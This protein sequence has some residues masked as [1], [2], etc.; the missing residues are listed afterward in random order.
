MAEE[1]IKT[2]EPVQPNT[3]QNEPTGASENLE[4]Q[5]QRL[6]V[7]Q[8]KMKKALD[9]ASSEAADYKKKY[10]A[11]LSEKEQERIEKAEKEAS[12]EEQFQKLLRENEIHKL[13]KNYLALGY[14]EELANK[15]AE[16]HYDHDSE[17]LFKIQG[18]VTKQLIKARES[19]WMKNRPPVYAGGE[20][21]PVDPFVEGFKSVR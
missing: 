8:A 15:A 4:E 7:E 3:E 5:I 21:D 10:N 17:T 9:K 11:T 19:E 18:D 14:S 13:E 6:L 20:E 2:D 1:I 12:R 16:A